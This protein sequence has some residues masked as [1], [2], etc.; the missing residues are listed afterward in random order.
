M[1]LDAGEVASLR[2][3]LES[4]ARVTATPPRAVLIISAHWE[5]AVP[6]V[7]SGS[8]PP[9]LFDYYGFP[10]ASYTI[11]WPAPGNPS[12]S[13]RV[14]ELLSGAGIASAENATRGFD[15]GTFIPLKLAW[16][17]AD[18]PVVQLS[19]KRGLDPA[20]HIAIGRAI[21]P[22]RDEGVFIIGSGMSFHN[23]RAIGDPRARPI[24][25][26]FDEWLVDSVARGAN[27]RNARLVEWAHAPAGRAAHPR[28]EH[29]LPLMVMAGAAGADVGTIPWTGTMLGWKLSAV[30]FG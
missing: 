17:N 14:R 4:L 6:T 8:E 24:S 13:T 5:E 27:E 10:P 29:L 20:E 1:G 26:T 23:L 28:E 16:P 12:L 3:Y 15:H 22:L 25:E 19:L 9:L 11:Q 18:V 21:A 30:Q 2:G 7:M